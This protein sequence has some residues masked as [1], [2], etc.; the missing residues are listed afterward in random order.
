MSGAGSERERRVAANEALFRDV[1]ERIAQLT[2]QLGTAEDGF[3]VVCECGD[4]ACTERIDV[5]GTA[6]ERV[7]ADPLHFFVVPGH[8]EP[9]LEDVVDELPGYLV[10]RKSGEAGE[11]I[12][13]A[14]DPRG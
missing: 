5:T 9:D 4:A 10:V 7:R 2:V 6:Y 8:E 12:T 13:D 1:N 3:A 11:A 14:S